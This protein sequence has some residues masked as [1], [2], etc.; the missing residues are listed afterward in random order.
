MAKSIHERVRAAIAKREAAAKAAEYK[1][2]EHQR[3]SSAARFAAQAHKDDRLDA[4]I[5][6]RAEPRTREELEAF[7]RL[8]FGP[9]F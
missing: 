6:G 7:D 4:V 8:M 3:R 1:A 9:E 2:G 5:D